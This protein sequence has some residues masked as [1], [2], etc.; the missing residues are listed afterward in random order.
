MRTALRE[1]EEEIGVAAERV[2]VVGRLPDSKQELNRFIITPIV[3]VLDER[4]L[5]RVD[6]E[7]I[8]SIFA[9]PLAE[10]L[11]DGGVYEDAAITAARG[12]SMYAFDYEGRHIWGFTGRMLK[13][14]VD[15]WNA[16]EFAL[17]RAVEAAF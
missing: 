10:I 9:V 14:F 6:G 4:T 8:A 17:R 7:E 3:G 11:A 15:A 5:F 16:P 12:K 1:L 13:S 2:R